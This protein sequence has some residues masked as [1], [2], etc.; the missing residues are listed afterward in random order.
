MI[1]CVNC[2]GGSPKP[3]EP[4]DEL[5]SRFQWRGCRVRPVFH[6]EDHLINAIVIFVGAVA[7]FVGGLILLKDM[8]SWMVFAGGSALVLTAGLITGLSLK[9]PYCKIEQDP[10]D[11]S[12]PLL[13]TTEYV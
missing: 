11:P 12:R 3:S 13:S 9:P 1:C 5:E 7:M 10:Q 2:F 8:G 4:V 6:D